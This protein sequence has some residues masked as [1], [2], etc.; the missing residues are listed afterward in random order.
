LAP[1]L[2]VYVLFDSNDELKEIDV[3]HRRKHGALAFAE[4]WAV[5]RHDRMQP[6]HPAICDEYAPNG[7]NQALERA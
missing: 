2:R 3:S 4:L 1:I 7:G 6:S 5:H